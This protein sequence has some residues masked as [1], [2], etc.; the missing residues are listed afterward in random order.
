ME[1]LYY[2]FAN[3]NNHQILLVK[4]D[5]SFVFIGSEDAG[6]EELTTVLKIPKEQMVEGSLRLFEPL[7]QQL[8]AYYRGK[9]QKFDLPLSFIGTPFQVSVWQALQAIPYGQV[10]SY[11]DIAQ[12]IN[13]PKAIR[14]VASAI[15]MNPL[16]IV[17]PCHRVVGSDGKLRGYRG[18][19]HVKKRLLELEGSL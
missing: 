18:G 19:L 17:V 13:K 4:N 2:F 12:K 5:T 9:L 15:G 1:K 8:A 6:F 3:I 16:S 7:V 10:V 14:A 11:K